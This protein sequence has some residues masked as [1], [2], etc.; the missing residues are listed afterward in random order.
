MAQAEPAVVRAIA[1]APER[2]AE[3]VSQLE[4]GVVRTR[5]GA[6]KAL[7]Q[8]SEQSPEMVYPFAGVFLSLLEGEKTVL[9]WCS[10]QI[11]G[12]LARVD[13]E[14]M[15][16]GA[17]DRLLAPISGHELIAAANAIEA[18]AKIALARPGLTDRIVGEILKAERGVYKT[19]EC[20]NVAIGHAL[21]ALRALSPQV[22]RQEHVLSFVRRQLRNSR[23]ATRRKAE[24][25]L[26][27][28]TSGARPRLSRSRRSG[29]PEGTG[30]SRIRG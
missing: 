30:S 14:G 20:R 9:R 10:A 15:I 2:V 5:Y 11:I 8:L 4:S 21:R 28:W 17:L 23:P 27:T 16:E 13:G 1:Q 29:L 19:P 18:A 24:T 25:L 6:A 3:L 22:C 12:N 7:K 26:R